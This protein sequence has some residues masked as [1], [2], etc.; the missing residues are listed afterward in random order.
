[1]RLLVGQ[2]VFLKLRDRYR[3]GSELLESKV[4]A[5]GRKWVQFD[6]G[7]WRAEKGSLYLDGGQYSSPGEIFLSEAHHHEVAVLGGAW[8]V[9]KRQ[10][11]S[12]KWGSAPAGVTVEDIDAARKLLRLP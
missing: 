3:R 12:S 8:T 6:G 4:T 9:F 11:E 10:V 7:R 5:V 2:V 1:M